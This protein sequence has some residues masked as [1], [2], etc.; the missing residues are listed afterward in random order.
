MAD[1]YFQNILPP[2]EDLPRPLVLGKNAGTDE[3]AGNGRSSAPG[4]TERSIRNITVSPRMKQR[5]GAGDMR[6]IS[7]G[8]PASMYGKQPKA[9]V[10][11]MWIWIVAAVSVLVLL[12]LGLFIFRSTTVTVI[13]RSHAVVFDQTSRFVAY[14]IAEAATGTLAYSVVTNNLEDSAVV[15]SEGKEHVEE[16]AGG[17]VEIFNEYGSAS[18]RLIKNTRF[19]TESGLVFR[20][21]ATVVI[22]GMKESKPGSATVTVFADQ[23]GAEYNIGPVDRFTLPGLKSTPDMYAKVYARSYAPMTG[24]FV[25]DRP[26]VLPSTLESARAEI[27]DRLLSKARDTA[28]FA[29]DANI[30][31]P[32]LMKITYE[33]LPMTTEAGGDVRLHERAHMEIPVFPSSSFAQAVALAAGANV[34]GAEVTLTGMEQVGATQNST[35]SVLGKD[36]LTFTLNGSALLVWKVDSDAL[37][38]ALAGRDNSAF[39]T[40]IKGFPGIQEA[41]ARIEPFWKG[42]FPASPSDIKIKLA[43][44]QAAQ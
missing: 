25:G 14:P 41:R 15:K 20:V 23:A 3:N 34:E 37:A 33:S 1:D 21:P 39:Q 9:P 38:S 24:G 6:D 5:V 10:R 22:P 40:I 32:D 44:V 13:P 19:V 16:R 11:R 26:S 36:S 17:T 43:P 35:S 31:F 2:S 30:V 18:V 12:V 29:N 28:A 27:R 8:P 7:S 42:T 4:N